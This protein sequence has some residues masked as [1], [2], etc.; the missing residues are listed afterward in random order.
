MEKKTS[1]FL[2]F[3]SL[4]LYSLYI[5]VTDHRLKKE[6]GVRGRDLYDSQ[7][8]F[9]KTFFFFF[10]KLNIWGNFYGKSENRILRS[11]VYNLRII[12]Y[13]HPPDVSI[14]FPYLNGEED[15]WIINRRQWWMRGVV[16][17][18]ESTSQFYVFLAQFLMDRKKEE[19][20]V[21]CH[22]IA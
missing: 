3:S 6:W 2:C 12:W 22:R 14:L 5:L 7:A 19:V 16:S 1:S 17:H 21:F 4:V 18:T 10:K 9:L 11:R 13:N 20:S 8:V 15:T